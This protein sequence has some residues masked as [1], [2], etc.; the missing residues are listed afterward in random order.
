MKSDKYFSV[1][2]KIRLLPVVVLTA[3]LC[4]TPTAS[5]AQEEETDPESLRLPEV[6]ITG[7]DRSKIQRMIPKVEPAAALPPITH[8]RRDEADLLLREGDALLTQQRRQAAERYA[9]ALRRDPTHTAALLR[10]GEV[11]SLLKRYAE[12]ADRYQQVLQMDPD[13]PEAHYRLGLLSETHLRDSRQAIRHYRAYL[14]L[15]GADARVQIW[16]RNLESNN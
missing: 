10:L 14:E 2:R 4:L 8:T 12:A 11:N 16:L 7:V 5:R 1:I 9:A 15:G 6:V 3:A 13:N